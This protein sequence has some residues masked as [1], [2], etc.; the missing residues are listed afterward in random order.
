M[1]ILALADRRDPQLGVDRLSRYEER[2][3]IL[4]VM[5]IACFFAEAMLTDRVRRRG[6]WQGRF[7]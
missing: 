2:Y 5:A 4:L 7:A 1:R 6:E 3:Q